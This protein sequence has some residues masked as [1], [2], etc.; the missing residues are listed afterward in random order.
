MP[1]TVALPGHSNRAAA[2]LLKLFSIAN[3]LKW[4]LTEDFF[5][6]ARSFDW[7]VPKVLY[8]RFGL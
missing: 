6:P 5:I 7:V 4:G 2:N 1:A 8:R 3:G